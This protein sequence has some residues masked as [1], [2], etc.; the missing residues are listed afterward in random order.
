MKDCK[1]TVM[2]NGGIE[3]FWHCSLC[4]DYHSMEND[5]PSYR[6]ADDQNN[7]CSTC[8]QRIIQVFE[9]PQKNHMVYVPT[10]KRSAIQD[11]TG[12]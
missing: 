3:F 12:K 5:C 1:V 8:G 4:N 9:T 10:E 11:T 7:I 6:T 2:P